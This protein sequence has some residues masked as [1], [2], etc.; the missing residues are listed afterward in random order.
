MAKNICMKDKK[1]KTLIHD[2]DYRKLDGYKEM[3][4]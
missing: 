2:D 1:R 3:A 4:E